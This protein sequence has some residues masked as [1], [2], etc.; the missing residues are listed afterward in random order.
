MKTITVYE[1][2][3]PAA[4]W[5]TIPIRTTHGRGGVA[6]SKIASRTD[7]HGPPPWSLTDLHRVA[8]R[9]RVNAGSGAETLR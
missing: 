1:D 3:Q 2:A 9:T 6:T 7:S 8:T 4:S 5:P